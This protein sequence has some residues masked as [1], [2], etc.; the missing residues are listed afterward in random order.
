M[1]PM[2]VRTKADV[3][4]PLVTCDQ[5]SQ[6]ITDAT[7]AN[8]RYAS[9]DHAAAPPH[10]VTQ[11]GF[12]HTAGHDVVAHR[13]RDLARWGHVA[14]RERHEACRLSGSAP[15]NGTEGARDD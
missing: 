7:M 2:H 15:W 8:V 6:R 4:Y 9:P 12:V 10:R 11:R 5:C 3:I 1:I 13:H 14:L